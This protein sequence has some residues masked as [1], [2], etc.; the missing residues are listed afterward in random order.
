MA[1]GLCALAQG[2]LFSCTADEESAVS[3]PVRQ[4][5]LSLGTQRFGSDEVPVTR[6]LP[7]GFV[8]Y[9][10]STALS[11]ITQIQ[12]YFTH[13][14]D[15]TNQWVTIPCQFNYAQ[16]EG[17]WVSM[18]ALKDD[19]Y[20]LYGFMPKN[21]VGA[22]T[23][24]PLSESADFSAGAVLTLNSLNAVSPGDVCV[25]VGLEGYGSAT[26]P[27]VPD[28]SSRLGRFTYQTTDGD[29]L[30]LL[31]DHIY[32]GLQFQMKVGETYSQLRTIKV[33]RVTLTADTGSGTVETVNATVTV[34]ANETGA[35]PL[36]SVVFTNN[37]PSSSPKPAEL[38][39]SDGE[40]LTTEYKAFQA[41]LCPNSATIGSKYVLET[42]Y[43]VYDRKGNLIRK[44]EK[45]QNSITLSKTLESGKIHT[46]SIVVQ[47]TFLYVLSDPDLDS[48]SFELN[49]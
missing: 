2:L 4:L 38:F 26:K 22:V 41:S 24:A 17:T 11:P 3:A 45:A 25:I 36:T 1:A 35:N 5:R 29:K 46:V 10:H 31:V 18:V 28:M 19:Q 43:D 9:N 7:T 30:Y 15:V 14:E 27:T 42:V 20:Y 32:A 8:A 47:P 40:A 16:E 49:E 48:P 12:C 44:D 33:K 21:D 39:S 13:D 23:I 37:T 6:A 34:T